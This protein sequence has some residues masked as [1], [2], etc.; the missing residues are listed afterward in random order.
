[1][2]RFVNVHYSPLPQYRGRANVNWAIINGEKD[3]A[4]SIHLVAPSLD[5]GNVL[6]QKRVSIRPIDTAQSLYERLNAIQERELGAAVLRAIAGDPGLPQDHRQATYGCARLPDDGE[7]DWNGSAIAI[8]RLIRAL[9]A[10][11]LPGAFTYL[12][13]R[14]IVIARAEPRENAPIYAGSVYRAGWPTDRIRMDGSTFSLVKES[15][16]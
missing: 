6:F 4:I 15:L 8:D 7:I 3:A 11:F 13:Q 1:M 14:R 9:S 2:S 10:P 12:Q 16:E 5:A